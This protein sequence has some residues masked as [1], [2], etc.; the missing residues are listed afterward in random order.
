[1]RNIVLLGTM[2]ALMTMGTLPAVAQDKPAMVVADLLMTTATVEAVDHATR[3]VTLKGSE[4]H[5]DPQ[6]R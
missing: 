4:G 2:A 3:T 5:Q 6:G 1:M